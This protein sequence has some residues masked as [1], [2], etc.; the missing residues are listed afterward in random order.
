VIG[1][2]PL[3]PIDAGPSV[4]FTG[5]MKRNFRIAWVVAANAGVA[6]FMFVNLRGEGFP[7][8]EL[9]FQACFEFV[10]EVLLPLIGIVLELANWKFARWLNVGCFTCA[11]G[12]WLVSAVW[13]RT[14]AFFGVL[15]ILAIGLLSTAGITEAVYRCTSN[16]SEIAKAL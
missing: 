13:W 3:L 6:C 10:F 16:S 14:D 1:N 15:L 8:R 7:G 2:N 5:T 11:G 9:D 12:Y 4:L